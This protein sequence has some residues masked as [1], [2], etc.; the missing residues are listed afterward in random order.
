MPCGSPIWERFQGWKEGGPYSS[1]GG[2]TV[3][4]GCGSSTLE[5]L[6]GPQAVKS[7]VFHA[8]RVA[9]RQCV[10]GHSLIC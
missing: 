10:S 5:L 3:Y 6:W 7:G 2:W 9:G 8:G 1:I 4:G